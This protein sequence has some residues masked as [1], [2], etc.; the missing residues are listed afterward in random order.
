MVT[1]LQT[2]VEK[3][4]IKAAQCEESARQATDSPQR[5]LYEVLA[6]YYGEL[7]TDFRQVIEKRKA[8]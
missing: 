6:R 1:D 8:A 7:A 5:A 3:Y 2:K 4:E